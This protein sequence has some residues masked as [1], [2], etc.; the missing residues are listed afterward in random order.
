MKPVT[1]THVVSDGVLTHTHVVRSDH[2][3]HMATVQDEATGALYASA[4]CGH[5]SH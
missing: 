2:H 5:D 1:H 4:E 3:A